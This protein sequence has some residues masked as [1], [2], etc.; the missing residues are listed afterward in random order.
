MVLPGVVTVPLTLDS[1][2]S[3]L[4]VP[5]SLEEDLH[6]GILQHP[7]G[8]LMII[9]ESGMTEGKVTEKGEYST[10]VRRHY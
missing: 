3:K 1:L 4:F 5:T 9:T 7:D 2:N 8:T 10:L 6:S